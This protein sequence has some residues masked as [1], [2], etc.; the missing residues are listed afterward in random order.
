MVKAIRNIENCLG[1]AIKQ[2]SPSELKNMA[3]AR[4]SI[5]LSRDMKKGEILKEGDLVM[6]RPGDGISPMKMDSI[7]GRKILLDLLAE[8]KLELSNLSK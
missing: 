8:H 4:K 6:K 3:I 1:S 5:H 7:V 2:P